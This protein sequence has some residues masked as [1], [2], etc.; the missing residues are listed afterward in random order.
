MFTISYKIQPCELFPWGLSDQYYASFQTI[1]SAEDFI[2]VLRSEPGSVGAIEQF[3][4]ASLWV[5]NE[6]GDIVAE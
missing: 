3:K 2:A 1:K 6:R 5:T 4:D